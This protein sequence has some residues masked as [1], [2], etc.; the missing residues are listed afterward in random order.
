MGNY[1]VGGT[2]IPGSHNLF[3]ADV[4]GDGV[5]EIVTGGF[6]YWV[7]NGSRR[8]LRCRLWVELSILFA[9][10]MN[11]FPTP[12]LI[13]SDVLSILFARFCEIPSIYSSLSGIFSLLSILFARFRT[14]RLLHWE[15]RLSFNSLCKILSSRRLSVAWRG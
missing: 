6:M 1:G 4:D 9:R 10:F 5:M 7:V 3:V 2:C 8:G 12:L 15:L 14:L 13:S 11:P